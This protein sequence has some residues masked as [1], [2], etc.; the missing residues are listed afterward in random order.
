LESIFAQTLTPAEI[1]VVDDGSVDGTRS[2][3]ESCGGKVQYEWQANAGPSAAR[4]RAMQMASCDYCAFLDA[5][6][7][8]EP[9]FLERCVNFLNRH[10]EAVAVS[11]GQRFLLGNQDD[12]TGPRGLG[13]GA[14]GRPGYVLE[15]FF[16]TWAEHDHVRTGSVVFRRE[17]LVEAGGFRED[18]RVAEDLELWGYIATLGS[19]GFIP[20][21]LWV[22][23]SV[24]S[25]ASNWREKQVTRARSCPTV[26]SWGERLTERIRPDD[27]Q[28]F[29]KV[30]GKVAASYAYSKALA[31]DWQS[32]MHILNTYG[33]EMPRNRFTALLKLCSRFGGAGRVVVGPVISLHES[34]K[35]LRLK[36]LKAP[37]KP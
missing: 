35:A 36:G 19:W 24:L 23:N 22:G 15:D 28:P 12:R 6:D 30:R 2:A 17:V 16:G 13:V 9:P 27:L 20:E 26:E 21:P 18:L 29:R 7:W 25:A 10:P 14:V 4:N 5:D 1:I 33:S 8:W 32:V 11:T 3:V 34:F 31:G 37:T